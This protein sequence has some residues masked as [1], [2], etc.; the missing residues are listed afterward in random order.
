MYNCSSYD[1]DGDDDDEDDDDDDGDGDDDEEDDAAS[2]GAGDDDDDGD[3]SGGGGDGDGDSGCENSSAGAAAGDGGGDG[4]ESRAGGSGCAGGAG[5]LPISDGG[6]CSGAAGRR[7]TPP[8]LMHATVCTRPVPVISVVVKTRGQ[9]TSRRRLNPSQTPTAT[10]SPSKAAPPSGALRL[11]NRPPENANQC[12]LGRFGDAPWA[13]ERSM[14]DQ[15]FGKVVLASHSPKCYGVVW[16][17]MHRAVVVAKTEAISIEIARRRTA[18][19][20][21][22]KPGQGP[23]KSWISPAPLDVKH[24]Y[25]I[26]QQSRAAG[27]FR[28]T[29]P[30][31]EKLQ[32]RIEAIAARVVE[33]PIRPKQLPSTHPEPQMGMYVCMYACTT[34]NPKP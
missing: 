26:G 4:G 20:L 25:R 8:Q 34:L 22:T 31:D 28:P 14:Y 12:R 24:I 7:R 18:A 29:H 16:R 2:G 21:W 5:G 15:D 32:P 6:A 33:A 27:D 19:G 13:A 11:R 9:C 23:E 30:A 3:G 17:H 1:D 10:E